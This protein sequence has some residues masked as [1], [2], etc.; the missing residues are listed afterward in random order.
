MEHGV[1]IPDAIVP[2]ERRPQPVKLSGQQQAMRNALASK[3]Q[4]L[5]MMYEAAL[6]VL[7]SDEVPDRLALAAHDIREVMEKL[8][9][10]IQAPV[11]AQKESLRVKVNSLQDSWRHT[12]AKSICHQDERWVGQID[13]PLSGF[14]KRIAVFFGWYETHAPRRRQEIAHAI[15]QLDVSGR[16]LPGRLEEL[17]VERWDRTKAFFQLV[18]H[19]RKQTTLAELHQWLSDF[20]Q[21]V[22]NLTSPRTFDDFDDIDRIIEEGEIDA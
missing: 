1:H 9:E 13:R 19:H 11:Q 8:P 2:D 16:R 14:L 12:L 3:N 18:A 10:F 5:G 7:A 22:L 21:C 17:S 20:E 15:Q 6:A 4:E